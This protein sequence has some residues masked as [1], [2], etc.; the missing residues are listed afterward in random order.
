LSRLSRFG[1]IWCINVFTSLLGLVIISHLSPRGL[2][3]LQIYPAQANPILPQPTTSRASALWRAGPMRQ[4]HIHRW[5]RTLLQAGTLWSVATMIYLPS[6]RIDLQVG[7]RGRS[8]RPSS[9]C[10]LCRVDWR[11]KP[12]MTEDTPGLAQP[13]PLVDL[14]GHP[15]LPHTLTACGSLPPPHRAPQR[16]DLS[17]L[18]ACWSPWPRES[19]AFAVIAAPSGESRG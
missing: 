5:A 6:F 10:R 12:A 11:N 4:A 19:V 13:A 16:A 14:L 18:H 1:I 17:R 15:L 7:P 8:C 3:T 9:P 2:G